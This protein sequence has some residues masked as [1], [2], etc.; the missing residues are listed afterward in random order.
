M[1]EIDIK[2]LESELLEYRKEMDKWWII[3]QENLTD[4]NILLEYRSMI[5]KETELLDKLEKALCS[6]NSDTLTSKSFK[7]AESLDN[8]ANIL[9]S[10]GLVK[11]AYEIDK[12][13]DYVEA[14]LLNSL[15]AFIR[16]LNEKI[17]TSGGVTTKIGDEI[18][19]VVK[20]PNAVFFALENELRNQTAAGYIDLLKDNDLKETINK[21]TIRD[22]AKFYLDNIDAI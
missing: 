6:T 17:D 19:T 12:I 7:L 8:I 20:K 2:N 11:E 15:E 10:K 4:P 16:P 3:N 9:E 22:L 14:N 18:V 21:M 5:K 13:A 1:N